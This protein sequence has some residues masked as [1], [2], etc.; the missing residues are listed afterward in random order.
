MTK[1]FKTYKTFLYPP[2]NLATARFKLDFL[3][4]QLISFILSLK[5][6]VVA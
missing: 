4:F 5:K 1:T 3:L 2:L 6:Y